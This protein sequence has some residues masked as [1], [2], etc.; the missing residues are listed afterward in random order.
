LSVAREHFKDSVFYMSI[1]INALAHENETPLSK[2]D[3]EDMDLTLENM[4]TS[5]GKL[6]ERADSSRLKSTALGKEIRSLNEVINKNTTIIEGR[7][8]LGKMLPSARATAG[9]ELLFKLLL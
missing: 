5:L 1:F 8:R 6:R 7:I 4:C 3:L 2:Q 9:R